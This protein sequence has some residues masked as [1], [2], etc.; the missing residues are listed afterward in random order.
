MIPLSAKQDLCKLIRGEMNAERELLT[1]QSVIAHALERD[2]LRDEVF[3]QCMRQATNN[4]NVEGTERVWLLLCLCVVSFQPSKLLNRYFIS[5]LKKNLTQG[6]G[7]ILQY[8]QWCID[9][10]NN[11]KVTVRE[12]PPSSVEIAVR[13]FFFF[14]FYTT[15]DFIIFYIYYRQ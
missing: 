7:R 3:V 4:P 2:E 14:F 13:V 1:I 11:T 12:H 15:S 9:N 5:F 8:V 10:C 6:Q